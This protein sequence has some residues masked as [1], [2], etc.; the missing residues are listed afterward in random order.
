[1]TTY[2]LGAGASIEYDFPTGYE[3]YKN[4]IA[5]LISED[6][7]LYKTLFNTYDPLLIGNFA[8]DLN[9][10]DLNSI[11]EFVSFHTDYEDIAKSVIAF[12][13]L[14]NESK[15]KLYN[16]DRQRWYKYF[17]DKNRRQDID[18]IDFNDTRILT[19]NYDRSFEEY[20]FSTMSNTY[21]DKLGSE[22]KNKVRKKINSLSI[23][24]IYGKVCELPWQ[25]ENTYSID[26]GYKDSK[27][28]EENINDDIEAS[29]SFIELIYDKRTKDSKL[30]MQIL[31]ILN[32]SDRLVFLGFGF[33]EFNVSRLNLKDYVGDAFAFDYEFNIKKMDALSNKY[34]I[35]FNQKKHIRNNRIFD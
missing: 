11:D 5:D 2:I 19:F 13:I 7:F 17:W 12:Y 20:L 10:N 1:M 33:D 6:S 21:K 14:I 4:A 15:G 29:K 28:L 24:H 9:N 16:K 31:S 8:D 3:M 26:Y 32:M 18:D 23:K 30:L 34:N 27:K 35:N 22:V 25:N